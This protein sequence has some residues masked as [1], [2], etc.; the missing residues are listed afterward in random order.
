MGIIAVY[1]ILNQDISY[2]EEHFEDFVKAKN[3]ELPDQS[4]TQ[5]WFD[6]IRRDIH[7]N[8]INKS[9]PKDLTIDDDLVS[10][11]LILKNILY[12]DIP[13]P[14]TPSRHMISK[15]FTALGIAQ[16]REKQEKKGKT[17]YQACQPNLIRHVDIH[18]LGK[19]RSEILYAVIDDRSRMI[20]DWQYLSTKET[21]QMVIV[22][23]R[24]IARFGP[25]HS[26]WLDNGGENH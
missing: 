4:Q 20:I 19:K 12:L 3:G 8:R 18:F 17:R 15:A 11:L 16:H 1:E 13:L 21:K 9:V 2:A 5:E 23:E 24:A 22:I 10:Y 26:I 6:T 7:L 25:H 14:D